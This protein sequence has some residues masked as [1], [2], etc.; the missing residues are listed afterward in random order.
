MG[1]STNSGWGGTDQIIAQ[2][3]EKTGSKIPPPPSDILIRTMQSDIASMAQTGGNL[4]RPEIIRHE[5]A[6]KSSPRTG[7]FSNSKDTAITVVLGLVIL[8]LSALA[9]YFFFF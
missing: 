5:D 7:F 8:A 9:V 4:P 2:Q 3:Q 1:L 6:G